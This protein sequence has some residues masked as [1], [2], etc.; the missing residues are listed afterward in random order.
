MEKPQL[1]HFTSVK[2]SIQY[3][4]T[5]FH[6]I[7]LGH[8]PDLTPGKISNVADWPARKDCGVWLSGTDA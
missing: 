7:E 5:A 1:L 2:R 8:Q 4:K 6:E 3:Q